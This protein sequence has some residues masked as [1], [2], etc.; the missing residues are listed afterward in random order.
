[1][2]VHV[3]LLARVMPSVL[4]NWLTVRVMVGKEHV[5]SSPRNLEQRAPHQQRAVVGADAFADQSGS[6]PFL[7]VRD[8][9]EDHSFAAHVLMLS[10]RSLRWCSR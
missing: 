2:P 1:M 10:S 4:R 3:R 9:H 5:L 6:R 7:A 8:A